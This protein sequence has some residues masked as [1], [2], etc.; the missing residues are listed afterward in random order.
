MLPVYR[1]HPHRSASYCLK[2]D[3]IELSSKRDGSNARLAEALATLEAAAAHPVEDEP[4]WDLDP[5]TE[6]LRSVIDTRR[7]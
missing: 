2:A 6:G 7:E 5:R 4:D 3:L 1:S